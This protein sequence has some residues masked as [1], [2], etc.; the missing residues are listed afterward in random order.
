MSLKFDPGIFCRFFLRLTLITLALLALNGAQAAF[1]VNND[2]TATDS[3]T[4]LTWMRCSMGQTWTGSTCSGTAGTYTFNQAN[5]LTGTVPWANQNDWRVPNIRELQTIVDRAVYSPAINSSAF[6]NTPSSVFWSG[7]P[8]A[9]YS[10]LAW[11][12][13][14]SSGYANYGGAFR[15]NSYSVRLVRG[16]QSFGPLLSLTRPTSDYVNNGNGTVTHKPTNLTWKRCAEGRTWNG[17]TCSGTDST[18]SFDLANTVGTVAFAGY[19]DWRV[20]TEEELL[21]LVDYTVDNPGPT[22]NPDMFPATSNNYFWSSSPSSE[23]S[24]S[25]WPVNFLNDVAFY[26]SRISYYSLR[27]VRNA[28]DNAGKACRIYKAAFD[29]APDADGHLYWIGR[30]DAGTTLERVAEEFMGSGEF[31]GRYGF[32][33]TNAQFLTNLYYNVLHRAPEQAGYDWWLGQLNSGNY[34]KAQALTSFSESDENKK[35]AVACY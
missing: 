11:V 31:I 24:V 34:T 22:I 14:F 35:Y 26:N 3:A 28:N 27:L 33:P 7:S 5:A 10:D 6:P 15:S 25:A 1:T 19:S 20:P 13:N 17:S 8:S 32:N 29:R 21:S 4:G 18:Y 30:L 9:S 2:G 23:N 12:V 16:G